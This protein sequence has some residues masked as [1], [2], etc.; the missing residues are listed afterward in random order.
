M[1]FQTIKE[2]K[3]VFSA[4]HFSIL[5]KIFYTLFPKCLKHGTMYNNSN[6]NKNIFLR[7]D[8]HILDVQEA[9]DPLNIACTC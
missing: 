7:L 4:M 6:E 8:N 9:P 1:T 2:A 5:H 3:K